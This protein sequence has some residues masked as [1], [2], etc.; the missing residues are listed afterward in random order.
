MILPPCCLCFFLGCAVLTCFAFLG[1][2][3][4]SLC[5]F[6]GAALAFC[7]PSGVLLLPF[8]ASLLFRGPSVVCCSSLVSFFVVLLASSTFPPL[9]SVSVCAVSAFLPFVVLSVYCSSFACCSRLLVP[10]LVLFSPVSFFLGALLFPC[11]P[12]CVLARP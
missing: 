4:S 8:C 3:F 10:W 11:G 1:V 12:S 6:C 2:L 5:S 7:G 9:W